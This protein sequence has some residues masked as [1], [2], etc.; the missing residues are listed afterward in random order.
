MSGCVHDLDHENMT[1]LY[2]GSMNLTKLKAKSNCIRRFEHENL[3]LALVGIFI[4]LRQAIDNFFLK[5]NLKY[6]A[7]KSMVPFIQSYHISQLVRKHGVP[8]KIFVH[9]N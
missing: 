7:K 3:T 5:R 4:N 8:M 2:Q 1:C 6:F 9:K